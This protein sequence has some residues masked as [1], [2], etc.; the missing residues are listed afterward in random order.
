[1]RLRALFVTLCFWMSAQPGYALTEDAFAEQIAQYNYFSNSPGTFATLCRSSTCLSTAAGHTSFDRRQAATND[2]LLSI[3]SNSKLVTAILTLIHVQKG[4]LRLDDLL[5][6]YFPE[7]SLWK[8]V[9][10]RHLLQH[11]SGIPPYLFSQDGVRRTILSV[12]N[13]HT[14]IWQPS[15]LVR[16]VAK[17]P[18]LYA[19][20][21][22]VEYNNTNYILLGMILQKA[23]GQPLAT[24][25]KA[26]LFEPLGM[27]NTYLSLPPAEKSRRVAGYMPLHLPLP[28]WLFNLLS[29]KVEKI[30]DYLDTTRIFDDSMTWAAGGMI[31]T[32]ENIAKLLEALFKNQL[33]SP[34]LLAEMMDFRDGTVLGMPFVYGLGLMKMPTSD[35]DLFG[36]GGLTPG[37]QII[38][39][40]APSHDTTLVVAQNLAPSQLYSVFYDLFH[41]LMQAGSVRTFTPDPAVRVEQLPDQAIHLRLYGKIQG[42]EKAASP[43]PRSIGYGKLRSPRH[44]TTY[45][46]F[47]TRLLQRDSREI[48]QFSGFAS[49]GVLGVSPSQAGQKPFVTVTLDRRALLERGTGVFSG[50]ASSEELFAYRG[51]QTIRADGTSQECISEV[52]DRSRPV[53]FQI[54]GQEGE[55]FALQQTV[56]FVGNIPLKKLSQGEIPQDLAGHTFDLCR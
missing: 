13:W 45:Q 23:T 4:S 14:R 11:A 9:T 34:A 49:S 28:S 18:L 41:T 40:Y 47:E 51:I 52:L 55:D 6:D 21:S 31:S 35:G 26:D 7:Y 42:D 39:N 54:D 12:F 30:G 56:K 3:G 20:G 22:R 10:V 25:L 1:M 2:N 19:P 24:L 38:S 33:I 53:S 48:L 29:Y 37:Y 17:K 5:T 8:G 32:T 46:A 50:Q 44:Y 16:I 43:F 36:H 27:Q 15:E